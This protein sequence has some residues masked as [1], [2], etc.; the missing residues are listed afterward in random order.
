MVQSI[1]GVDGGKT[2]KAEGIKDSVTPTQSTDQYQVYLTEEE[3]PENQ[4]RLRKWMI[5]FVISM[6]GLCVA[7]AS[8]MVSEL[9]EVLIPTC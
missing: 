6:G 4:P 1:G 3:M 5:V 7:T 8:S 9:F 2:E